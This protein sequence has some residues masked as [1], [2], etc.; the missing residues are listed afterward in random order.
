MMRVLVVDDD[1][2]IRNALQAVLE[3]RGFE[4]RLAR[5]GVEGMGE[6]NAAPVDLVFVDIFMPAMDG[7]EFIRELR[8]GDHQTPVI[9]MS[10]IGIRPPYAFGG[11]EVPDYLRMARA[12]GAVRALQK[13]FSPD[14]LV[15]VVEESLGL[16]EETGPHSGGSAGLDDPSCMYARR[17]GGIS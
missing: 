14:E 11:S 3:R 12:L 17:Q 15:R 9:V 6:I 10:G 16:E 5:D 1:E 13:P 7:F 2:L 8:K 4:V